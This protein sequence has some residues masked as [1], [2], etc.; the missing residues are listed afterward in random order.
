MATTGR[1]SSAHRVAGQ[2]RAERRD[3]IT[4]E[5][6][7][8]RYDSYLINHYLSVHVTIVSVVLA[9][10][11][12]DAAALLAP[13]TPLGTYQPLLWAMWGVSLLAVAV[14]YAGPMTG[15]IVLPPRIP[16]A[17]DLFLPLLLGVAEFV[18]FSILG[19]PAVAHVSATTILAG[20][21]FSFAAFGLIAATSVARAIQ[22]VGS[23]S[24]EKRLEQPIEHYLAA[25]RRDCVAATLLAGVSIAAGA[26]H[27]ANNPLSLAKNYALIGFVLLMLAGGFINHR[28]AAAALRDAIEVRSNKASLS[29]PIRRA[30]GRPRRSSK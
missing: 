8:Q 4:R 19:S 26:L 27:T 23:G 20:W 25:E 2:R 15:A 16:R 22:V 5:S 21:W 30:P 6:L 18:M 14:A 12:V 3:E 29:H 17:L 13:L 28:F 10:A 24:Y 9:V 1:R 11:G 7:R